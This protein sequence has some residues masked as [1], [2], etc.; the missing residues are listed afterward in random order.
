MRRTRT[1]LAALALLGLLASSAPALALS[2]A[3][4]PTEKYSTLLKQ[5]AAAKG[6]PQRVIAATIDKSKHHV[7]VTLANNSRPLVVYPAADDRHLVDLL[8]HHHIDVV[9]ATKRKAAH[10]VLR[11]VAAGVVVVLVLI[12][13]GVWWYTRGRGDPGARPSSDSPEVASQ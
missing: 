8:L 10:H 4:G 3:T 13:G 6:D 7:R 12:G 5:I 1:I 9:Y 2:A 11:Y